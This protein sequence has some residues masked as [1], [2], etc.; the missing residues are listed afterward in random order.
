MTSTI[1]DG[2]R[3]HRIVDQDISLNT[4]PDKLQISSLGPQ[5][6]R[7]AEVERDAPTAVAGHVS[8]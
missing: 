8:R 3:H 7:G 1:K 6:L 4:H 5:G 2:Q